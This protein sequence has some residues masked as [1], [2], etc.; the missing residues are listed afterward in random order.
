MVERIQ[1]LWRAKRVFTN[2][3]GKWKVSKPHVVS[4]ISIVKF[5]VDMGAIF[6]GAPRGF[7]EVTGFKGAGQKA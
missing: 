6:T 2:N 7:T 5:P 4:T 3:Q 1:R